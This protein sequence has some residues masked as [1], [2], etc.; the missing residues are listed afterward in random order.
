ML[1]YV[2]ADTIDYILKLQETNT[3]YNVTEHMYATSGTP[4]ERGIRWIYTLFDYTL[5]YD[6][7]IK[8]TVDPFGLF[9]EMPEVNQCVYE[10]AL[11]ELN[12]NTLYWS[13]VI[14]KK[15]KIEVYDN[16]YLNEWFRYFLYSREASFFSYLHP[17]FYFMHEN[18]INSYVLPYTS[19]LNFLVKNFDTIESCTNF[20]YIVLQ[21]AFCSMFVL[22]L[23]AFFFSFYNNS[24]TDENTIDQDY[25]VA[26]MTVE[27]EEEIASVDD[28]SSTLFLLV[29]LFSWFFYT[30]G[31]FI[32]TNIPELSM[33]FYN[34]PFLYYLI[35]CIPTFLVYDF[36]IL[37]LTYLRGASNSASLAMEL[38]YDYIAFAAFYVRLAVQNVRILLMLFTY[39]ALYECVMTF[40]V[41]PTG[42]NS[43]EN[44]WRAYNTSTSYSTYYL[45]LTIPTQIIYWIYELLHTFFV[46]T[47]QFIAFFAMVFWLFLFLFTMFVFEQQERYFN[48]RLAFRKNK[49]KELLRSFKDKK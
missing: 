30:N 43:Y 8:Y 32:L 31:I 14:D 34:L 36:G 23:L 2:S 24:T 25:L 18:F 38:L 16:P 27:S 46:V 9:T 5:L 13:I 19:S 15:E 41:H 3:P 17:E 6:I 4:I 37:F 35:I 42:F 47:A 28:M 40:I 1:G 11:W 48:E 44:I 49:L 39:F 20:I 26:A 21:V 33:L 29:F 10:T 12:S 22:L 45:L 7:K